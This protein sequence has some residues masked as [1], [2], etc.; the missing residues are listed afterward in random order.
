MGAADS[1]DTWQLVALAATLGWASGIRL[2]AV[3]FI[4]GGS[5]YLDWVPLPGGLTVLA[6]P[7]VLAASGFMFAVEFLAD[8]IPGVDTAWDAVQT[9]V[10]IPAGAAL[11]ASVFGD[12]SAAATLAAAI[13]GGTLAAGSHL[14]K[15]GSRMAIN[16]SPEPF[17]NW[18]ASFGEDLAVGTVLWLAW[19]CPWIA[20]GIV[21][22]SVLMMIWLVP[23]LVRLIGRFLDRIAGLAGARR[24]GSPT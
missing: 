19:A 23:K 12:S 10:R 8:K 16:T 22:L 2:Y 15:A 9:F 21:V 6:H 18:A 3:L 5:G 13:L 24:N 11:A 1:F 14:T 17:S 20:L 7:F 4:V